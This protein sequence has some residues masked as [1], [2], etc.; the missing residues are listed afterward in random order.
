MFQRPLEQELGS[1]DKSEQ[2]KQGTILQPSSTSQGSFH[3][4]GEPRPLDLNLS[5]AANLSTIPPVVVTPSHKNF[6]CCYFITV[7]LQLL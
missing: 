4:E 5:N 7:I 2:E 6:F 1:R 3:K